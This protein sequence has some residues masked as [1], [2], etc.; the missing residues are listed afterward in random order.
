MGDDLFQY[1]FSDS[2]MGRIYN[3]PRF[4]RMYLQAFKEIANGPMQASKVGALIDSK[5]SIFQ[6]YGFSSTGASIKT[7]IRNRVTYL[8]EQ[9][10]ALQHL[11][12]RHNPRR[13]RGNQP[14]KT[15]SSS[16]ERHLSISPV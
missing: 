9:T 2:A 8:N 14:V 3:T 5:A 7:Y 12:Q 13:Q 1:N 10:R 6:N 4:R 15:V 16:R 11:L